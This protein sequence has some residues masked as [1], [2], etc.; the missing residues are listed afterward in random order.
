M[1]ID[2][3]FIPDG[4]LIGE[5]GQGFRYILH[6][7]NP[8]RIMVGAEGVGIGQDALKSSTGELFNVGQDGLERV[9]VIWPAR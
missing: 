7:M 1:F 5:E 8:E 6:S 4:D 9:P 2:D 3:L